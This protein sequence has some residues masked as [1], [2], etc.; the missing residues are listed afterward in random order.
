LNKDYLLGLE[1]ALDELSPE[2]GDVHV[3]DLASRVR[4]LEQDAL[5]A[6]EAPTPTSGTDSH[7]HQDTSTNEAEEIEKA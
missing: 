2:S 1:K 4:A 3:S 6:S 5:K 7:F